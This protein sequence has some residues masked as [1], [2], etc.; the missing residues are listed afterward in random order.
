MLT[1]DIETGG[2]GDHVTPF[3]SPEGT[4]GEWMKDPLGLFGDVFVGPGMPTTF[5]T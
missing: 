4:A 2:F 3:H 5:Y 1:I